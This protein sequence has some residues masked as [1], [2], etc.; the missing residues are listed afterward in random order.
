M[1][2]EKIFE[3][4]LFLPWR[5]QYRFRIKLG[6]EGSYEVLPRDKD[7]DFM[8]AAAPDIYLTCFEGLPEPYRSQ[9]FERLREEQGKLQGGPSGFKYFSWT[10]LY[11]PS[12][13]DQL[14]LL[15]APV[16][17]ETPCNL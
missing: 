14:T 10:S 15:P 17:R 7:R 8:F 4:Y 16:V 12:A 9:L 11:H 3:A 1:K 5:G 13:K 2:I 6:P